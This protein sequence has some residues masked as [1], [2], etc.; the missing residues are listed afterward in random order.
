M[1]KNR[2]EKVCKISLATSVEL[3][4]SQH[5]RNRRYDCVEIHGVALSQENQENQ[6]IGFYLIINAIRWLF[7]YR[8]DF[9]QGWVGLAGIGVDR[10]RWVFLRQC[11][12]RLIAALV[13]WPEQ[14]GNAG[15]DDSASCQAAV[16]DKGRVSNDSVA[17]EGVALATAGSFR[18]LVLRLSRGSCGVQ[19]TP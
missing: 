2:S 8:L 16:S 15:V 7:R 19:W 1:T 10:R 17:N 3:Y 18:M 12:R 9:H 4:C 11:F 5:S 14:A 13:E 6:E